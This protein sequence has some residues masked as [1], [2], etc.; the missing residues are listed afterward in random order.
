MTWDEFKEFVDKKL[1]EIGKDGNIEIRYFDLSCPSPE[2]L[3]VILDD[4]DTVFNGDLI[5]TS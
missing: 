1:K 4:T 3:D 5:I 2:T